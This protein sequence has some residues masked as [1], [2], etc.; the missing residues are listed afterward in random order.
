[1]CGNEGTRCKLPS[2]VHVHVY[3]EDLECV[4]KKEHGA[5]YLVTCMYMC[6]LRIWNVWQ[7]R[8]TVQAT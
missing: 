7:R 2:N 1:M 8:N 5:N 4:A 3:I 6:T